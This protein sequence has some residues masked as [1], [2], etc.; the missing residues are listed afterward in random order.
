MTDC[1]ENDE[2]M[3]GESGE[4]WVK[5]LE[6]KRGCRRWCQ[7]CVFV[8]LIYALRLKREKAREKSL[9]RFCVGKFCH[10]SSVFALRG[11][12]FFVYD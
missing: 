11:K 9:I 1:C 12:L 6:N 7:G 5:V 4:R 3:A 2:L 8:C 10:S